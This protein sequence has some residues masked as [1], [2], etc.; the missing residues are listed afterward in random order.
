[1]D[2]FQA[3]ELLSIPSDDLADCPVAPTGGAFLV[4]FQLDQLDQ[5]RHRTAASPPA[6]GPVGLSAASSRSLPRW[7]VWA[8]LLTA[9]A[10][11][12]ATPVLPCSSLFFPVLPCSS[13]FFPVLPCSLTKKTSIWYPSTDP[14]RRLSAIYL[15]KHIIGLEFAAVYRISV[16][17]MNNRVH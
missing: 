11:G 7:A 14:E 12:Q 2:A 8:A 16:K 6:C 9:S 5:L 13:L 1:M 15:E 17:L 10:P 4:A 3:S